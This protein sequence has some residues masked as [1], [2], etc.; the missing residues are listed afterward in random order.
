MAAAFWGWGWGLIPPSHPVSTH[1]LGTPDA[2]GNPSHSRGVFSTPDLLAQGLLARGGA[3]LEP[4]SADRR[5]PPLP[6]LCGQLMRGPGQR[7]PALG[8]GALPWQPGLEQSLPSGPAGSE[9][10]PECAGWGGGGLLA[11]APV[12]YSSV[13]LSVSVWGPAGRFSGGPNTS[14][15]FRSLGPGEA[16]WP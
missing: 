11:L 15:T 10:D 1:F 8:L 3:R 16:S 13:P 12:W 9:G 7:L 2:R 4:S 14:S 5:V 6:L